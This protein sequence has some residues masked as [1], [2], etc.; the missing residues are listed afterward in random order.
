MCGRRT[1]PV[2]AERLGGRD[3]PGHGGSAG[4]HTD[5]RGLGPQVGYPQEGALTRNAA[6]RAGFVAGSQ[7]AGVTKAA[8]EPARRRL[9]MA[10]PVDLRD[11]LVRLQ[12]LD[13]DRV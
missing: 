4:H 3:A 13:R 12:D 8:N 1:R 7:P 2:V 11:L 5:V 10:D 6:G 9:V